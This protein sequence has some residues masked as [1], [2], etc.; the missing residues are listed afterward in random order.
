MLL[1]A[2]MDIPS[3]KNLKVGIQTLD[4]LSLAGTEA[5][6]GAQPGQRQGQP[7]H[8][9]R[10]ACA[11]DQRRVPRPVRHRGPAGGEPRRAGRARQAEVGRRA[12]A[13]SSSPTRSSAWQAAADEPSQRPSPEPRR[14]G[15]AAY[16]QGGFAINDSSTPAGRTSSAARRRRAR[17][18]SRSC[19]GKCPPVRD[20]AARPAAHR[21]HVWPSPS[22]GASSQE[23]VAARR[24]PRRTSSSA[25]A[26]RPQLI[27][28]V[29][30]DVLGYGPI[31]R[32]PPGRRA[33]PKS[34]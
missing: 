28:D 30:D 9:R 20:R 14:R 8:R 5:A 22:C 18:S 31:D 10:R 3:I 17:R 19:A 29:T 23:H 25:R 21:R 1:V 15:M 16:R 24:S 2:S 26:R 12:G 13:R 34:W 27:Q 33:S 6:A 7:R 11:R 4:L 32:L